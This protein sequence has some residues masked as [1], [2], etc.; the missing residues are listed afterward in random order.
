V[1]NVSKM[2]S[3][4]VLKTKNKVMAHPHTCLMLAFEGIDCSITSEYWKVSFPYVCHLQI[5]EN[6]M[7]SEWLECIQGVGNIFS[8]GSIFP[9]T[10]NFDECQVIWMYSRSGTWAPDRTQFSSAQNSIV[11][12]GLEV[13][14]EQAK[15][16]ISNFRP[17]VVIIV[18]FYMAAWVIWLITI[19]IMFVFQMN[20]HEVSEISTRFK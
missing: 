14:T 1:N 9:S 19:L 10:R 2:P 11:V 5:V 18:C 6:S 15:I 13:E 4:T 8:I 7:D 16:Y 17:L 12:E 3:L 20:F